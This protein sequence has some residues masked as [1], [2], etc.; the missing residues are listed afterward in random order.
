MNGRDERHDCS[1]CG[2]VNARGERYQPGD[3]TSPWWCGDCVLGLLD[4]I[5]DLLPRW[6]A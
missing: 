5:L 6:V 4:R 3:P 2:A 1:Q